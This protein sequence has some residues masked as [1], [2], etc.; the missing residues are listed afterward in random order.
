MPTMA[1]QRAHV[2]FIFPVTRTFT[3]YLVVPCLI[4]LY[5]PRLSELL[6]RHVSVLFEL[7]P[8][9]Y[10]LHNLGCQSCRK[11]ATMYREV[12]KVMMSIPGYWVP[13]YEIRLSMD[14]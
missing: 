8:G 11:F 12:R 3:P 5:T 14:I 2:S 4:C 1:S 9:Q 6:L 10:L 13:R 7:A